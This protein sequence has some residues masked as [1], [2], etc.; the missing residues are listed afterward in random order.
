MFCVLCS[1]FVCLPSCTQTSLWLVSPPSPYHALRYDLSE[2]QRFRREYTQVCSPGALLSAL[3]YCAGI[4]YTVKAS[5]NLAHE[6]MRT[7]E[8]TKLSSV[9]N[10]EDRISPDTYYVNLT[11]GPASAHY[12]R[13]LSS[14]TIQ[15]RY[16]QGD[17][18]GAYSAASDQKVAF[19]ANLRDLQQMLLREPSAGNGTFSRA[20]LEEYA[21]ATW[22]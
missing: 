1:C 10:T 14:L 19:M 20:T 22:Q 4:D 18:A 13:I 3:E 15:E 12:Q 16:R 21:G 8:T 6:V 5:R 7:V 2:A 9:F 17:D 11:V